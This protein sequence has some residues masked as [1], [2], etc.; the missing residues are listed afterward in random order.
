MKI[1]KA[2]RLLDSL[3]SIKTAQFY[4]VNS[5]FIAFKTD[6]IS[7]LH[8][9][10]IDTYPLYNINVKFTNE[11]NEAIKPVLEKYIKIYEEEIRKCLDDSN[12]K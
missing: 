8:T 9:P 5:Y 3:K 7:L 4:Q 12:E 6:S 2:R 10:V 11:L 1:D